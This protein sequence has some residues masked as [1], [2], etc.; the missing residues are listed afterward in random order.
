MGR[1]LPDEAE[2]WLDRARRVAGGN[3]SI[4]LLLATAQLSGGKAQSASDL[5]EDLAR[6]HDL[7]EAWM[8]LATAAE[9]LSQPVRCAAALQSMLAGQVVT[10]DARLAALAAAAAAAIGRPGWCALSAAHR[11][12]LSSPDAHVILDGAPWH[13]DNA[14]PLAG[15]LDVLDADGAHYLGSPLNVTRARRLEG[16]VAAGPEGELVGWAWHPHDPDT[17]PRLELC[18]AAGTC[19]SLPEL[20]PD[21]STRRSADSKDRPLNRYRPFTLPAADIPPGVV[22]LRGPD[23][24][25]LPGSPLDPR[26]VATHAMIVAKAVAGSLPPEAALAALCLSAVPAAFRAP[27]ARVEVPARRP[28]AIVVPCYRGAAATDACL[29]A[30]VAHSQGARVIVVEDCSPEPALRQSLAALASQGAVELIRTPRNLGFPGAAN[31][32]LRAV[33]GEDAVLLNSDTLVP[34]DWLSRLGDVAYAAPDVG[35]VTPFSNDATLLS[36][37]LQAGPNPLP[38]AASTQRLDRAAMRANPAGAVEIPTGVGFCMYLRHDCLA[39]VGLLREQIF[40][41]G[42]CEEN[43]WCLRARHLGW[44]HMAATGVFVGHVGGQSFGAARIALLERNLAILCRLYPGY[45]ALIA[46]DE[47]GPALARA[48]RAI[49]LQRLPARRHPARSRV[50]LITHDLGGGV[51]RQINVRRDALRQAGLDTAVLRPVLARPLLQGTGESTL[52]LGPGLPNLTFHVQREMPALVRLLRA[53]NVTRIELH[54]M[55][56]HDHALLGLAE[57]LGVPYEAHIHDYAWFCP[58]V[59]LVGFER[60]YCGEP[61]IA[62]CEAC[63]A[64]AGRNI[65]EDIPVADLVARSAADLE[66]AAEVIA[67]SQDTADRIRRHF[68][69]VRPTV[70]A[71]DDACPAARRGGPVP[72]GPIRTVGVLGAIGIEKGYD[73][74]LA[75]ARDAARRALPLRFVVAGHTTGD[76]RLIDTGAVFITG[77]Y[78]PDELAGLL[79]RHEVHL[80]F[81]PSIWPETWCFTLSEAWR[82]GL[83]VVA[84]DLGAPAERIRLQGGGV[85]LPLG[86]PPGQ[87]NQALLRV[88]LDLS[89][90]PRGA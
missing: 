13:R 72:P 74:L 66:G 81:L 20:L 85:L 62:G 27:A 47:Y 34:P 70:R 65:D 11:L 87:V 45:D 54:H 31:L 15:C 59:S 43:D 24:R 12:H 10:V 68:P 44:R 88:P 58:R 29:A 73:V 35:S 7:R 90:A 49:D 41:Q 61:D 67:P 1:G 30:V 63:V 75:C 71:W 39:E 89:P 4:A 33:A 48:R 55:L 83:K 82:S 3:D 2:R 28:A 80:G 37:P 26:P 23:G 8:G 38:D 57:R 51:E 17:A 77:E 14:L 56:G 86:C 25:D 6:R 60:R 32:G 36:Y 69:R 9:R 21:S 79:G 52:D 16:F 50:L 40:A 19:R 84:F 53:Q 5:F 46:A 78:K 22:H 64:D 42:Y 76:A 18:D